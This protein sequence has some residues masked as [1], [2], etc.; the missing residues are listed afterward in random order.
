MDY[1][2]VQELSYIARMA[3]Q[4]GRHSDTP[5][6]CTAYNISL[7]NICLRTRNE[8]DR[9]KHLTTA[10]LCDIQISYGPDLPK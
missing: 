10:H 8:L 7:V 1:N 4:T 5:A 9:T 6:V 2:F 3:D